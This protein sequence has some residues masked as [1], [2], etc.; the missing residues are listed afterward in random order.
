[1]YSHLKPNQTMFAEELAAFM[2][3]ALLQE[4]AIFVCQ[5]LASTDVLLMETAMYSHLKPNQTM[6]AV[7]P[8]LYMRTALLLDHAIFVCQVPVSTDVLL[9]E[10]VNSFND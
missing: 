10:T 7:G 3:T 4:P 9:M 1:M 5:A 6:F 8:A 2:K